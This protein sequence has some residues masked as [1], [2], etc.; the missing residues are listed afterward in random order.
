MSTFI[1]YPLV[2]EVFHYGTP[3]ED[4]LLMDVGPNKE[5]SFWYNRD[6]AKIYLRNN[7][8]SIYPIIINYY[9]NTSMPAPGQAANMTANED[10]YLDVKDPTLNNEQL[11]ISNCSVTLESAC[12]ITF[13]YNNICEYTT[14]TSKNT[15]LISC[16]LVKG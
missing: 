12:S 2:Q 14:S 10:F 5:L 8:G 7:T 16:F 13:D 1:Q 11:A 4:Q 3:T 9:D 15:I 6:T